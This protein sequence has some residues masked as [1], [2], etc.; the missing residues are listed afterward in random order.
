MSK[1]LIIGAGGYGV[2]VSTQNIVSI[3]LDD[4]KPESALHVYYDTGVRATIALRGNGVDPME[5]SHWLNYMVKVFTQHNENE[6]PL[7]FKWRTVDSSR[8]IGGPP[9]KLTGRYPSELPF[10]EFKGKS[11]VKVDSII[12]SRY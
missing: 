3:S 8:T 5:V 6:R 7:G 1:Y 12:M 10:R 4:K 11:N 2:Y 9:D